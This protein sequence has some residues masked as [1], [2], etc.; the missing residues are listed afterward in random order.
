MVDDMADGKYAP[1]TPLL[2]LSTN[3][4]LYFPAV[5]DMI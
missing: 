2:T 4:I 3:L 5:Y 1:L